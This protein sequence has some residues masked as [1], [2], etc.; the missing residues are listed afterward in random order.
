MC[1]IKIRREFIHLKFRYSYSKCKKI[2]KQKFD[3]DVSIETLKRRLKRFKKEDNWTFEDK[4]TRPNKIHYKVNSEIEN[5]VL[6]L[7]KKTN[8]GCE[9]LYFILKDKINISSKDN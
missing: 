9:K 5:K 2:I 3:Y 1:K 4:S 8:Y 7:R 6:Y